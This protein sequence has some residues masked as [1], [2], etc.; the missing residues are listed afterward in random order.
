MPRLFVLLLAL[1][2]FP[3]L[4]A[5]ADHHHGQSL[6]NRMPLALNAEEAA[7]LR[8]EMRTF[9]A[10]VQ[11]IVTSAAANDMTTVAATAQSLGMASA[12]EVPAGLRQKLPLA[13]KHLGNATHIGFDDLARDAASMADANLTMKQLGQ[14]MSNCVS[15]HATFRIDVAFGSQH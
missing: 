12:H 14:V 7:Y 2:P 1:L 3:A 13:F 4:A 8:Q 5:E 9:L 10:G 15:C 6:E 11:K